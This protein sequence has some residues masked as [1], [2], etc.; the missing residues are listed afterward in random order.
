MT[1]HDA[2]RTQVTKVTANARRLDV[3]LASDELTRSA[4]AKIIAE[5]GVLVNGKAAKPSQALVAGDIVTLFIPEIKSCG[6]SPE[7]IPI[8]IVFEDEYIIVIDKPKGMVVH[9]APGHSGGTLVN[10][11]LNRC[12]ENLSGIN[13]VSRPGIV[14]RIDKDTSGLLVVAKNDAAHNGLAALLAEHKIQREYIAIARGSFKTDKGTVDAPIGRD[15]KERKRMAVISGGRTAITHFKVNQRF[16][17]YSLITATLETGRTHQI[18]VHMK[19]IG[20]PILGDITYGGDKVFGAESQ[21]LH[22]ERLSFVHPI[23]NQN[24]TFF[25]SP[26][27]Y[28]IDILKKLI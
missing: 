23:S 26:P 22:A 24:M 3:F 17:S 11:L 4:A 5:G 21:T 1:D 28:F 25:S 13:G 27:K 18:R 16:K 10:A 14:H 6:A 19:Y 12:A 15:P 9:P 7:D 2:E 8:D 20:H